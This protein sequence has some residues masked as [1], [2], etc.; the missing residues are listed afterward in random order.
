MSTLFLGFF[1]TILKKS[2]TRASAPERSSEK[3]VSKKTTKWWPFSIYYILAFA[4]LNAESDI[5]N[6]GDNRKED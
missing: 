3:Y 5:D 6:R 1:E 2:K 4:C